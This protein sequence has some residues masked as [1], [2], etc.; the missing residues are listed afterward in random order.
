MAASEPSDA[1]LLRLHAEGD[2]EAF[3][4]LVR[5]HRD[6]LWAVAMRT[7]GDRDEAA[8]AV[9]DALVSA[10]RASRGSGGGAGSAAAYRGEAAV[11]TWL[12]RI[13]VNSCLDRIRRRAS[14][15][16]V[17]LPPS[18]AGL[19][20]ADDDV[21]RRETALVVHAALAALPAEQRVAIVLVDLE[22]LPVEE[23]A[24][25]LGVPA[26]TVK[27]RCSRGRARLLPLLADLRE[28]RNRTGPAPVPPV[29]TQA[30]PAQ[31]PPPPA[32]PTR[33]EEASP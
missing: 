3:G 12:H 23:A 31:G 21:G 4:E 32:A 17:P 25:I 18:D 2:P 28:Q 33:T 1:D 8:D 13:V 29:P 19:P 9:Q 24:A 7:L 26:G 30:A 22:G 20:A 15:P 16:T 11:S 5:R 14:R 6:R 10:L 27:S